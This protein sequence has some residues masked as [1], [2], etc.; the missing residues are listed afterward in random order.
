MPGLG[1]DL[2]HAVH[3]LRRTPAFTATAV[4]VLALGIGANIA[5]WTL[6]DAAL[7]RPVPFAHADQLLML[8]ERSPRNAHNR[9]SPLNFLDW[10]EQNRAFESIAAIAGGGRTLTG[11]PR[12]EWIPG[13]AVTS[14]FFDVLGV[15]AIAGR[16]FRADD[17]R[18]DA[19]FVV[20][21]ERLWRSRYGGDASLVGRTITLDGVPY[22]VLGVAPRRFQIL[23]AAD[24]W[25]LF[26]PRR[27]PEQRM[28]HYMQVIGRLRPGATIEQA[29]GDMAGVADRIARVSPDTNKDWRVTIEPLRDAIVD[30]DLRTTSGVL[31]AVVGLVLLMACANVASLLLARGLGRA[32][33]IAVRAAIGASR[34]QIVRYLLLESGVI[35]AL[36]GAAGVALAWTVVRAAP[37]L[38]PPRTLP[39]SMIL[40]FDWR[41][42]AF[43]VALTLATGAVFGLAPAWQGA[44]VPLAETIQHGGRASTGRIGGA[45]SMLVVGEVAIAVLLLAAAALLIR[46]LGALN[47]IDAGYSADRVLTMRVSLPFSQYRSP[48]DALPFYRGIRREI[49][50]IPGVRVAAIGDSLPLDGWNIGQGFEIEGSPPV[51]PSHMTSAHYQIVSPDYFEALGIPV[52]QGRT[53]DD[54][55]VAASR[56]VCIVN[57]EFARRYLAG[58]N[59]LGAHVR[60]SPMG[61]SG[62]NPVSREVVGVT[63][64]IK[65][66]PGEVDRAVE[67]YVP[68]EQNPWYSASIVVQTADDPSAVAAAVKDA[69][70]RVD[71]D[72]PVTNVRTI[73]EIATASTAAPRFRAQ[74]VGAFAAVALGLAAIGVSGVLALSVRQRTREFGIRMALGARAIDVLSIVIGAGARLTAAGLAI[75]IAGAIAF[76]RFLG[77]LLFGVTPLD[78]MAL[79]ASAALLGLCAL[80]ACAAPALKAIRVSPASTLRQD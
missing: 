57:E 9:V 34:A 65:E 80:A 49:A 3:S 60:V 31:V 23:F 1:L 35:A 46:T 67:I 32:R 40:A 53:F 74:L 2:R 64:Q 66:Q 54:H 29:R 70:A 79:A 62:A 38:L 47:A 13:Q 51:D 20:I 43:A 56:P 78:P 52:V 72:Q 30:V 6:A 14:A 39:V 17:A 69:V 36:G 16:T 68:L 59:P 33:E 7:V 63:H 50:S 71:R 15:R 25:T 58:R 5:I 55:D 37:S 11:G 28:Q 18:P 44:R 24:L 41:V 10:S 48:S 4:L 42:A 19:A 8:W 26:V 45:R 76:T 75:G 27:S 61:M 12:A 22:T 73:T 21:S 77:T